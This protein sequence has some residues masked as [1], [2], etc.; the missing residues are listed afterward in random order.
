MRS[1]LPPMSLAR[2][3]INTRKDSSEIDGDSG[4]ESLD[5]RAMDTYSRRCSS[6]RATKSSHGRF[7]APSRKSKRNSLSPSPPQL[8][9]HQ[10]K[11]SGLSLIIPLNRR[12]MFSSSKERGMNHS[13]QSGNKKSRG[14]ECGR[15]IFQPAEKRLFVHATPIGPGTTPADSGSYGKAV[16]PSGG[17]GDLRDRS[18]NHS[19]AKV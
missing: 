1:V 17:R 11:K 3:P 10:L 2:A 19:K 9:C 13:R 8:S 4:I 12:L 6:S 14:S 5:A 7:H 18:G 16:L 15:K